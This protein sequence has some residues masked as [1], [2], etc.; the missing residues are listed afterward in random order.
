MPELKQAIGASPGRID[1]YIGVRL[2]VWR[3]LNRV[4]QKL[5]SRRLRLSRQQLYKYERGADRFTASKVYEISQALGVTVEFFF[6]GLELAYADMD[7][8]SDAAP[9]EPPLNYR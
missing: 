7:P 3:K 2:R 1:V 4:S 8:P 9:P 5:L 6:D